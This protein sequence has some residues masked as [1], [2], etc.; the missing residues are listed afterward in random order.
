MWFWAKYFH[1]FFYCNFSIMSVPYEYYFCTNL[2]SLFTDDRSCY[3]I[4]ESIFFGTLNHYSHHLYSYY[5][6]WKYF[7]SATIIS[8]VVTKWWIMSQ[9]WTLNS[10]VQFLFELDRIF[11]TW[12]SLKLFFEISNILSLRWHTSR[13]YLSTKKKCRLY[14]GSTQKE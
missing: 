9:F 5:P 13:T 2:W 11:I 12:Y 10:S 8:F 3:T 1:P 7:E 14:H 6:L 4:H